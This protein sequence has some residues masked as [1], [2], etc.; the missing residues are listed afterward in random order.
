VPIS[1]RSSTILVRDHVT[2]A[3]ALAQ[4]AAMT[5]VHPAHARC[6]V[7]RGLVAGG[8]KIE[9]EMNVVVALLVLGVAA[10]IRSLERFRTAKRSADPTRRFLARQQ[11]QLL[12]VLVVADGVLVG[13]DA[14]AAP[15]LVIGVAA[16]IVLIGGLA[17][18]ERSVS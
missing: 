8:F 13:L 9:A 11:G 7:C 15:L 2:Q 10:G 14:V 17:A 16:M 4:K 18:V 12:V 6:P 5:A 3:E 1:S